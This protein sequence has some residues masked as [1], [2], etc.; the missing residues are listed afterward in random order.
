MFCDFC[1]DKSAHFK[2]VKV[3]TNQQLFMVSFI[4]SIC[5]LLVLAW[6][7]TVQ[8]LFFSDLKYLKKAKI[9]GSATTHGPPALGNALRTF[10]KQ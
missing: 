1:F 9:P 7:R 2:R 8:N 6:Y 3:P 5:L 10:G 4:L